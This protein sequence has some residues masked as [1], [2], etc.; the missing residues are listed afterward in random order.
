MSGQPMS[1]RIFIERLV[2]AIA[3]VGFALLLWELRDLLILVFGAVLVSVILSLIALPIRQ[4]LGVPPWAGL[5][6]AVL[7]VA[8]VI[9]IALGMFGAETARQAA[10]LSDAIPRAWA[11]LQARLEPMGLAE[12]LRQAIAGLEA[13]S[14]GVL[15]N[16]GRIAMSIG[17]GIA[18]ALLVLVGGIYLAAQ[19][20]LYRGGLVKLVPPGGRANVEQALDDSWTALRLWLLGRL[21]SMTFIG[22]LTGIGLWILGVPAALALAVIAFILE[23]VPYVGPILASIPAILLAFAIDP[24]LALWVALLYVVIQQ[25]EGNVIEPLVQQRAVD[26]P[27][28]LLLFSIVAG[29][30]L[31]GAVGVIFAAPLAVVLFVIV[32]RL[33]V[34]E[35]LNTETD[36]PG[37][38]KD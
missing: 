19:P 38:A 13:N 2:I 9:G 3:I 32:K 15:S 37:E 22:L 23:F 34:R 12:P 5:L 14:G 33:Y 4:R 10:A 30:V 1:H 7:I 8:G 25:L 36:M 20:R 28:A 26:L 18:D 35:A 31:F 6:A 21:V 17:S 16:V 11:A 27:P 29:G 24:M